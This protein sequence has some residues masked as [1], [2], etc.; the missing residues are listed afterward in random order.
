MRKFLVIIFALLAVI[1][2][3]SA[4]QLAYL[5][6]EQNA[7]S[8]SDNRMTIYS[9]TLRSALERLAHLPG[10]IAIHP[11]VADVL[12]AGSRLDSFNEYLGKVAESANAAALY[13]MNPEG[14]TVAASNYATEDS[15]V[16][17][18]YGFRNYF[19]DAMA[20]SEGRVF[21]VGATTGR[22]GYFVSAPVRDSDGH[23]IGAAVVKTEFAGLLE[24]W[25]QAGEKL[26]IA[27]KN[28][29]VI[30]A[31]VP[32]WTFHSV[33]PLGEAE[34]EQLS[35]S[36]KYGDRRPELLPFAGNGLTGSRTGSLEIGGNS[37]R[38]SVLPIAGLNWRLHYLT[39]LAEARKAA[40][41]IGLLAAVLV[42]LAGLGALY[43]ASRIRQRKLEGEAAEAVRVRSINARLTE[44]IRVRKKTE[45]Q[46]REMQDELILTSRLAALGKMSAAIVHEV[47]QPVSA[48]RNFASSGLLLL[49][50][51][52][53]DEA[54]ETLSQIKA[55]TDRLAAIT[56]ELLVFSRKPVTR[57]QRVDIHQAIERLSRQFAPELKRGGIA[58]VTRLHPSPILISG[59]EVRFEQ[60][61]GNLL[62]NAIDACGDVKEPEIEILTR[63]EGETCVL[64]IVDNGYG[65][66][67]DIRSQLFDP[68]FTTK[69]VGSGVGLGLALCYAIADEAG[70]RIQVQNRPAGG[71]QFTVYLPLA[72]TNVK[73]A[74]LA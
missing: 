25:R 32:A 38:A 52:R 48:I 3:L 67:E 5:R 29:V 11:D 41:A 64:V 35:A 70:G 57:R 53:I 46:L 55:M 40:L 63:V 58:L 72:T 37:Y 24:D 39:P 27:D 33:M 6:A 7:L 62:R 34:K 14:V 12:T 10:A 69:P 15:F 44:E 28:G 18:Y 20:G 19:K 51:K 2:G 26:F 74:E 16:G 50:G 8:I 68:F 73:E 66:P 22:P 4:Y 36:R 60:L 61:I 23:I 56:S 31:S 71:A 43:R 21:A 59:S 1:I 17:E 45:R 42:G 47:N 9:A 54:G 13:L 30:L 65:I 49:S